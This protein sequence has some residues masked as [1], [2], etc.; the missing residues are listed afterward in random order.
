MKP[1]FDLAVKKKDISS[2]KLTRVVEK[3]KYQTSSLG[4]TTRIYVM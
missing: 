3:R 4:S 1:G 2:L